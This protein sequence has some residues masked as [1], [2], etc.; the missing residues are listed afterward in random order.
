MSTQQPVASATIAVKIA[1][2]V[3][4]GLAGGLAVLGGFGSF[5]TV[6]HLAQPWFGA[7][8]W[9]VPVGVDLGILALLAW[10]LLAEHLALPW[11]VLRWTAW[12]FIAATV[13]LNITAARDNLTAAIMHAA[14]PTLFV[15]VIEGARH[16]LRQ[17]TGLTSGTRIEPIPAAR[18][19][20]APRSSFLMFRHM[21]L[22]QVTSYRHGLALENQRWQAIARLQEN[23]GRYLWRWRAPLHERLALRP[24]LLHNDAAASAAA[25]EPQDRLSDANQRLVEVATSILWD[26]QRQGNRLSQAALARRMRAQGQPIAND[27]LRWLVQAAACGLNE[28]QH[29]GRA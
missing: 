27:R 11:P 1:V 8:A 4:T 29:R 6:R 21:V 5:A 22:W 23:Y 15:V 3:V 7:S 2:M 28:Q 25:T 18:W 14:M 9:I 24:S 10:D 26:A 13:Y 12:A 19:I 20:L 16:L 17:V